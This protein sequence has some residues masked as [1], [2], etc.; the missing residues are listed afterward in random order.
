M[1]ASNSIE[2]FSEEIK[3]I[4]LQYEENLFEKES[5]SSVKQRLELGRKNLK[6]LASFEDIRAKLRITDS[7]S[8]ALF[9]CICEQHDIV[10]SY[11][12]LIL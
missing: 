8:H 6:P 12:N 9:K 5:L 10:L 4:Q 2:C 11:G 7:F 1:K 3:E